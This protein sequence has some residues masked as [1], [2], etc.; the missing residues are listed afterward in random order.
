MALTQVDLVTPEG[1]LFSGQAEMVACRT[2]GGD[3]AFLANHMAY[4]GELQ[5]GE[6]RVVHPE[7]GA[8]DGELRFE[9]GG[10]F[11]EVYANRV[12]VACD[13]ARKLD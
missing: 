5:A 2:E 7:G 9:V 12:V 6:L 11:V 1:P 3:I 4:V 13:S 8:P 10:G